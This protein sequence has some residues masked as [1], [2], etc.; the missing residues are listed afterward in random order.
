M[1]RD[2]C[3]PSTHDEHKADKDGDG[4]TLGIPSRVAGK[5]FRRLWE[6]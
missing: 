5:P 2:D 4:E 3:P 6:K 1:R